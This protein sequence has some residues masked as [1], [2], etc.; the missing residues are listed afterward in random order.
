M[1][2]EDHMFGNEHPQ[3]HLMLRVSRTIAVRKVIF[4]G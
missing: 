3:H 1:V 4:R 2:L